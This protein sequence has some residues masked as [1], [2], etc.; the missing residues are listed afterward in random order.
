[1][2]LWVDGER[3]TGFARPVARTVSVVCRVQTRL[4]PTEICRPDLI[5]TG[6]VGM[7][8]SSRFLRRRYRAFRGSDASA[9]VA[10]VDIVH[11]NLVAIDTDTPISLFTSF[12][13]P[14]SGAYNGNN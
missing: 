10:T 13:P 14:G 5:T 1:M 6:Y 2:F 9:S 12:E 4:L 11:K 8:K 3:E 7:A